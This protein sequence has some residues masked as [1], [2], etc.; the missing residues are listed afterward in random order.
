MANPGPTRAA[1]HHQ[2]DRIARRPR[3]HHN[4]LRLGTFTGTLLGAFATGGLFPGTTPGG[5]FAA[6]GFFDTGTFVGGTFAAPAPPL[7]IF[8]AGESCAAARN[9]SAAAAAAAPY[10]TTFAPAARIFAVVV[11]VGVEL[12]LSEPPASAGARHL[13]QRR[14]L[15]WLAL[16]ETVGGTASNPRQNV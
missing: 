9:V 4:S 10:L 2:P 11:G 7:G 8:T 5:T 6:A 1:D 14:T 13:H 15:T 3:K 12:L 16:Q